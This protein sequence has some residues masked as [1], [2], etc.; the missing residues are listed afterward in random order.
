MMASKQIRTAVVCGLAAAAVF[1]AAP[2]QA[3]TIQIDSI[4]GV[5]G[6]GDR[7]SVV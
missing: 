5:P 2:A 7:K 4:V 6:S 1:A 3:V